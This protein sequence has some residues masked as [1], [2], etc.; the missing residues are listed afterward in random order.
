MGFP[1]IVPLVL[2]RGLA[3]RHNGLDA[4]GRLISAAALASEYKYE[5]VIVNLSNQ[6]S[7]VSPITR[8]LF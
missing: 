8:Q 2:P 1:L 4:V 6:A 5:A 3:G 7:A